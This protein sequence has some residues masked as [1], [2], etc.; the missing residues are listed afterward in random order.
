MKKIVAAWIE[1][2][3]EFDGKLEYMAYMEG[4][5]QKGQRF[6]EIS[7]EQLE[8]GVMKIRIRK[9]YNNNAFPDDVEG[10]E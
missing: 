4:L 8:S 2:I 10:G 3:L 5:K 9:Q 1:Q 6:K 7:V